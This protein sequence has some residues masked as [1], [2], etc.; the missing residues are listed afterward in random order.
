MELFIDYLI[1]TSFMNVQ[2][3]VDCNSID[4]A[5]DFHHISGVSTLVFA[6]LSCFIGEYIF[7]D[8]SR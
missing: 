1:C 7:H 3:S 4:I 6:I 2:K 8:T 5:H